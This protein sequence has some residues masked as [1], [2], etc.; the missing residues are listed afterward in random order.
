MFSQGVERD[1]VDPPPTVYCL[2]GSTGSQRGPG[3][4]SRGR[5][6]RLGATEDIGPPQ[7]VSTVRD[8]GYA[9]DN[10]PEAYNGNE[11]TGSLW[12]VARKR[13]VE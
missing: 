3:A 9:G 10:A 2:A 4:P 7:A 6:A 13:A 5:C 11:E 8:R 12:A 1:E